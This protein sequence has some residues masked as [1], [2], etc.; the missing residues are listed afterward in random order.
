M[1]VAPP[2]S[3]V[4][5]EVEAPQKDLE[6]MTVTELKALAKEAGLTGYSSMTKNELIGA[7]K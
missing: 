2:S 4:V 3:E 6:S 5:E 7:L 1:E